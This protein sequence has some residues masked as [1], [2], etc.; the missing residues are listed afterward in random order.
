MRRRLPSMIGCISN[1]WASNYYYYLVSM[2]DGHLPFLS[3]C[4]VQLHS[5]SN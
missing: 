2:F 1:S 3:A 5:F 4:H